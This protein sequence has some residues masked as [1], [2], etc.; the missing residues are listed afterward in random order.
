MGNVDW[1]LGVRDGRA[2]VSVN[3]YLRDGGIRFSFNK[4]VAGIDF[5]VDVAEDIVSILNK[6]IRA[7]RV[8]FPRKVAPKGK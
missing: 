1:V 8:V 7:I 5:D 4:K 6:N 3:I 2:P